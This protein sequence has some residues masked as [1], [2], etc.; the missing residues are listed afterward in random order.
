MKVNIQMSAKEV[1]QIDF[2]VGLHRTTQAV[3][4]LYVH[5]WALMKGRE[6]KPPELVHSWNCELS[7]EIEVE[8]DLY[9]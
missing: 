2:E 9:L 5:E 4:G 1:Q 6:K 8:V 3:F 7:K